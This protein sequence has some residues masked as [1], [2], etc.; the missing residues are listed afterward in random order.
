MRNNYQC[1]DE[2]Q[3]FYDVLQKRKVIDDSNGYFN[4]HK[5][6]YDYVLKICAEM[7]ADRNAVVLDV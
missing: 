5:D 3:I 2:E 7:N 4:Y 6:R 1:G